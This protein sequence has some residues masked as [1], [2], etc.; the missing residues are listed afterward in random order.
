MLILSTFNSDY[1]QKSALEPPHTPLLTSLLPPKESIEIKYVNKSLIIELS[2]EIKQPCVILFRLFDFLEADLAIDEIKLE[3]NLI[4]VLNQIIQ[5]KQQSSLP[6]LVFLCPSPGIIYNEQLKKIEKEFIEKCNDSKIHILSLSDIEERYGHFEFE[7]PMEGDTH[8]PY[9]PK[10]Y[11][12]IA[13][14]I[15]RK[16]HAINKKPC[17]VIAVDCDNTLWD[18][19]AADLGVEGISFK[20]HNIFLQNYLVDQQKK[21]VIIALCS[22]NNKS[23]VI[24]VFNQREAEMPLKFEHL[25]KHIKINWE[26]KS[27]NIKELAFDLKVFP[28]S[29]Y[30]IDDNPT[31]IADVRQ[32]P[33]IVCITMPQNLKECKEELLFDID[34]HKIITATDKQRNQ[35]IEQAELKKALAT[36]FHDPIGYLRSKELGQSIVVSGIGTGEKEAIARVCQ[37][38]GKTN[39]FNTFPENKGKEIFEIQEMIKNKKKEIVIGRIE[40]KFS[41]EDITAISLCSVKSNLLEIDN[42]FVSCRSFDRGIEFEIIKHLAK[43][44]IERSIENIAI[45]FKKTARNKA[46]GNFL[47]ILSKIQKPSRSQLLMNALSDIT[48]DFNS[49]ELDKEITLICPVQKLLEIELDDLI[50]LSLKIEKKSTHIKLNEEIKPENTKINDENYLIELKQMVSS[51]DYLVSKYFIDNN[52]IKSITALD[53]RVNTLCN[54]LLGDEPQDKSLVARGLDS[55]KATELRLS[56]YESENIM[57]TIQMLL[58]EKTTS[59]TLIDY[60]KNSQ[61]EKSFVIVAQNDTIYNQILPVSFQQQRIWLAEQ[62][63]S[64]SNSSNYHMLACYKYKLSENLD[65]E[66]FEEDFKNA[67]HE[68]I[69]YYDAFGTVFKIKKNELTQEIVFPKDREL[70]FVIKNIKNESFL[71]EA[72]Q[73]ELNVPWTM[74]DKS[75]IRITIFKDQEEKNYYI[76]FHVHHAIFD[77][78]S[79][80]NCLDTL[81]T[82]YLNL[83]KKENRLIPSP[84]LYISFINDQQKKLKDEVFQISAFNFWHNKFSKITNPTML[85]TDQH[86]AIFRPAS[87][88]VAKR[89]EFSLALKEV[90]A[91][92]T[93]VRSTGVTCFSAINALFALLIASYTYQKNIITI[94][95]L[96]GRSEHPSYDKMVGFFI[97]LLVQ[98]F[99]LDKKLQLDEYLK[100]VHENFLASQEFQEISFEKIQ[101]ILLQQNIKDI[102]LNPALIYQSY[103]IPTFT[104]NGEVAELVMPKQPIIFDLRET[105]RFGN[106]TLFAQEDQ[107]K[108]NFVIE[109]ASELFSSDFIQGFAK[110]FLHTISSACKNSKQSLQDISVVCDEEREQLINLGQGPKFNSV[111]EISL[112]NRFQEIVRKYPDN[113]ALCCGQKR[114]SYKEVD[115]QSTNL[116]HALIDAKVKQGDYVGIFLDANYLFFIAE[117]AVIK[118]GAVFIPLSKENPNERLQLIIDDAKINF[119]IVDDNR[120]DLFDTNAQEHQL[121]P[122]NSVNNSIYLNKKLPQL[123][124]ST[125]EFCVLYTSGSTGIPKGVVLQEKGILRVIVTPKMDKK[126]GEQKRHFTEVLPG[127]K[128]AQ[129][130]NQAFDAAQLEFWLA[131]L[132]GAT[133]VLIDKETLLN[134]KKFRDKLRIEEIVHMWLTAGLFDLYANNQPDIFA[135]KYLK[136]LMVGGDVVHKNTVLKVLNFAEAPTIINGYGPTETSIFVLTHTFNKQTIDNFNTT[137]IGSPI[138]ETEIEIITPFGGKV[139]LGGIGELVVRG[140]GVAKGYLNSLLDEHRFIGELD[141]RSYQTGD[142]VKY[143]TKA[144][145][146]MFIGRKDSQQVKINGNLVALEEIRSCLSRHPEVKQ[147]EVSIFEKQIVAFYTL[148]SGNEKIIT[149]EKFYKHLSKSLPFYMFPKFYIKLEDFLVNLNGKLDKAQFL[150]FQTELKQKQIEEIP[151]N[152]RNGERLLELI[153]KILV[154]FPVNISQNLY[155]FGCDSINAVSIINEINERFEPEF[156]QNFKSEF[157]NMFKI[158]SEKEFESYNNEFYD[159][160]NYI[161]LHNLDIAI[162]KQPTIE[163]LEKLLIEKLNPETNTKACELFKKLKNRTKEEALQIFEKLKHETETLR[164]LLDGDS[165][166]PC[167]IFLPPAGGGINCFNELIKKIEELKEIKKIHFDNICYGIEDSVFSGNQIKLK[168][169]MEEIDEVAEMEK[170]AAH[171]LSMIIDEIQGPFILVGYSFGGML[172][173]EM[174]A[175]HEKSEN[176]KHLKQC[177]LLDTWVVSCLSNSEKTSLKLEVLNHCA[178]Q[179]NKIK[180]NENSSKLLDALKELCE[181]HQEIG[182]KYKPKRLESTPVCLIK[183]TNCN[184]QFKEMHKQ[185]KNNFLLN[186]LNEK[187]FEIEKIN[188]THYDILENVEKNSLAELFSKKVNEIGAKKVSINTDEKQVAAVGLS[189]FFTP[190]NAIHNDPIHNPSKLLCSFLGQK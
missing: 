133:L 142:L 84:P 37:L 55:L 71:E 18:G 9:I 25:N 30:F 121:I 161:N 138:N 60:I 87:E 124:K 126:N 128:V 170:I 69:K 109:Y 90:L 29:F 95:A 88:L 3:K 5:I 81:S 184:E 4:L 157:I 117:L 61:L 141:N 53:T 64:A 190:L 123:N 104:L 173:L 111:E 99:D 21:G 62:Q 33:N 147:V 52:I 125:D 27:K 166:L 130:A 73:K 145:Q 131:T 36:Q 40:D 35:L 20:E 31:E 83:T 22:K 41:P 181:H 160:L 70:Y 112:M 10:F 48:I 137:L 143:T 17:K 177:I 93:L 23:T 176:S 103:P 155:E 13:A 57:I 167:I 156:I 85:P 39:Q 11:S 44:A 78:N 101:K 67:C 169:T 159:Y 129:T 15:A 100:T 42:F 144:P 89:Y 50:R 163:Y 1:L 152:T 168:T 158:K 77:A 146:I 91:L 51:L 164:L 97:N 19:V 24:D 132:N 56:L 59:V 183:A 180:F 187:L 178:E 75:L 188:A 135:T 107:D 116:A 186:F 182:F 8:I 120:K 174:A 46:A 47:N 66:K 179:R 80:K 106:F 28:D 38:S 171:Y 45:K 185:D 92:K 72:I 149:N 175:K 134:I 151:P 140:E 63:E 82:L 26:P 32:I 118:A 162:Q 65:S 165:S 86:L 74:T 114:L 96:N 153:Q 49:L 34:E 113:I 7:N 54:H 105:C 14:L 154:G 136:N 127:E 139:P 122:I 102:L 98:Q 148:K 2:S 16:L 119:F 150:K 58:C 110:N 79:L 115:Q 172:A 12:A 43:F 108:L 189:S 76:L 6:F 68:L 94:T